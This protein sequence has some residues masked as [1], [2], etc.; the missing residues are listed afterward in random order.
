MNISLASNRFKEPFRS[1]EFKNG[2]YLIPM[3]IYI[4]NDFSVS[5]WV[6]LTVD[7][8]YNVLASFAGKEGNDM[9]WI[10]FKHLQFH[11]EL[12]FSSNETLKMTA[13]TPLQK[14][15][16][17]FVTF[18]LKNSIGLM[19]LNGSL[20]SKVHLEMPKKLERTE[21]FIGKD[22]FDSD[23]YF[24]EALY[25]NL[26]IYKGALTDLEVKDEFNKDGKLKFNLLQFLLN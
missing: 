6:N 24:A 20:N 11:V 13:T 2:Y 22:S 16:W 1:T 4:E 23:L 5:A 12:T 14:D 9:I 19:Y 3:P 15:F 18:V 21:N 26:K 8:Q 10:G 25:E 17:T 7:K